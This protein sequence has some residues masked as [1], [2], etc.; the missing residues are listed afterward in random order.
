MKFPVVSPSSLGVPP[1][2]LEWLLFPKKFCPCFSFLFLPDYS[3]FRRSERRKIPPSMP[4]FPVPIP[5]VFFLV[6]AFFLFFPGFPCFAAFFIS[7][8]LYLFFFITVPK[9]CTICFPP[10]LRVTSYNLPSCAARFPGQC[11]SV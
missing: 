8:S 7:I 10:F 1:V 3:P 6:F 2:P 4:F 9:F 11:A 5:L